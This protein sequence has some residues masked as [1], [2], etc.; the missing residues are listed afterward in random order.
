MK[1][2]CCDMCRLFDGKFACD[3]RFCIC[4]DEAVL[5]RQTLNDITRPEYDRI[6]KWLVKYFPK[7]KCEHCGTTKKKL[8]WALERGK[9]YEMG[10]D[11]FFCLCMTCHARYDATE[12]ARR[13]R[14]AHFRERQALRAKEALSSP[15]RPQRRFKG[16]RPVLQWDREGNLIRRWDFANQIV[17]E[18]GCSAISIYLAMKTKRFILNSFWQYEK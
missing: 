16:V 10:R 2:S 18:T 17:L 14:T 6:H 1:S 12:E 15:K 8:T 4:H 9:K 11:N 5:P 3:Y 13:N 7:E